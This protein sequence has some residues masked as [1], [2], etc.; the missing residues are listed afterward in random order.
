[1]SKSSE[2][3]ILRTLDNP[4]RFLFWNMNDFIILAVPI[5]LGAGLESLLIMLSGPF[6]WIAWDKMQKSNRKNGRVF[7]HYLY[8]NLPTSIFRKKL[9]RVPD[10]HKRD[11]IL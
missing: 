9:K 11:L 4:A 6:M 5:F 8:W 7:K 3:R 2:N 1:M 10:S